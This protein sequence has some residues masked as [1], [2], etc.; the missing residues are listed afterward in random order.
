MLDRAFLKTKLP[1]AVNHSYNTDAVRVEPIDEAIGTNQDLPQV[2]IT[3]LG[4]DSSGSRPD[5]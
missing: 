1:S 3:D 2:V 4:H 5:E